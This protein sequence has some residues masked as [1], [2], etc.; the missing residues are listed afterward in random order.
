MN[1][2]LLVGIIAFHYLVFVSFILTVA[3][4]I[5]IL[6]WY[7]AISISSLIARVVVSRGECP[8]TVL[9]NVIRKKLD[10]QTSKGFLK[11]YILHI[12]ST[13]RQLLFDLRK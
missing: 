10:L 13:F 1:K 5:T 9:E 11:E 3:L 6:P 7:V 4:S 2:I 8:L 12:N